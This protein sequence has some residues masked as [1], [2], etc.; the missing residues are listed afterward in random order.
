MTTIG[1][2]MQAILIRDG[3][4]SVMWGDA[5]LLDECASL[6]HIEAMHPLDRWQKVL[7]GL[8][9]DW[10][11]FDKGYVRL[12]GCWQ[13]KRSR[14]VRCFTLKYHQKKLPNLDS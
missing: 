12:D 14:R 9:R 3:I 5:R 4:T 6:C 2:A 7:N 1:E 11:R 13:G 10:Q 8:E